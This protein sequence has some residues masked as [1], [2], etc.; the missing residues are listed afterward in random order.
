MLNIYNEKANLYR[1]R[2]SPILAI[3]GG[4]DGSDD[5]RIFLRPNP[6]GGII[7]IRGNESAEMS[8]LQ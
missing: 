1:L 7:A 3:V 6:T 5:S 4:G 2:E 8:E